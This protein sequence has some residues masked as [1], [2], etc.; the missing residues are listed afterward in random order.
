M[1]VF[2]TASDGAGIRVYTLS[3]SE[4]PIVEAPSERLAEVNDALQRVVEVRESLLVEE[5]GIVEVVKTLLPGE[6]GHAARALRR[7]P[8]IIE[9]IDLDADATLSDEE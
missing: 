1:R 8:W 4:V 9:V 7:L 2:A 6:Q 5:L 3:G